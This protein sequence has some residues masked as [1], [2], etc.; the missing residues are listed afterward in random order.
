MAN[1]QIIGRVVSYN[2]NTGAL[3]VTPQ[4]YTGDAGSYNTWTV[5][6]TGNNGTM[7][8]NGTSGSSGSSG[9]SYEIKSITVENPTSSENLIMFF[10]FD[11]IT[12]TEIQ[13]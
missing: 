12:I 9:V 4:T 13:S 1:P 3:V 8:T 11:A 5:A 10:V 2:S 7:G 6:L